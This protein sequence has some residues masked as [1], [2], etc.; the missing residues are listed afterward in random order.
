[1]GNEVAEMQAFQ[2]PES[3]HFPRLVEFSPDGRL[4][5]AWAGGR[6]FVIDPAAGAV[7]TLWDEPDTGR[8]EGNG[9]CFTA[10]GSCVVA[11][12]ASGGRPVIAVHDGETGSVLREFPLYYINCGFVPVS[13]RSEVLVAVHPTPDF[14]TAEF[15]YWNPI[16]DARSAP[17]A[18]HRNVIRQL[19][20]S[21]DGKWLAGTFGDRIRVWN[22]GGAKPP[23]RA[24]HR[25]EFGPG[26]AVCLAVSADGALVV[27]G[28]Y[29]G[30]FRLFDLHA[31]AVR[32]VGP[33]PRGACRDAAF[34]PSR[35]LLAFS[36]AN[37]EVTFYDAARHAELNRFAWGV[38]DV[39]SMTFS[40]DGLRCAA[41]TAGRVV[42]W[43]V[44]V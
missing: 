35:P 17:F 23:A 37:G 42:I 7:R 22:I 32:V 43:D 29:E 14:G 2:L 27:A 39:T 30:E 24:A 8:A 25:Q 40:H 6:V 26:F 10:D 16:T 15:V 4:L 20:V 33:R 21:A 1:M 13:G 11:R 31:G 5:A 38:G 3:D 36:G 34:H 41:A 44:D 28:G 18:Q 19:A 9:L 12:H